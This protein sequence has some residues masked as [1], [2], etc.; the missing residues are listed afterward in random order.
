MLYTNFSLNGNI[1]LQ[2]TLRNFHIH[3]QICFI[4]LYFIGIITIIVFHYNTGK[5]SK[6]F[7]EHA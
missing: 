7:V 5:I 6:S 1:H 4:F 3:F 2:Q